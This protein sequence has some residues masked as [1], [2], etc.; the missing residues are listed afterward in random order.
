MLCEAK[1]KS[2]FLSVNVR[3]IRGFNC[4]E[5]SVFENREI[6]VVWKI[7]YNTVY[8]LDNFQ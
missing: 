8:L 2:H 4:Y 6:Q 5:I 7:S 3:H 1:K